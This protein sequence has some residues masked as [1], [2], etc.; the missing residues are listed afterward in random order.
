MGAKAVDRLSRE[1]DQAAGAKAGGSAL[2]ERGI[3]G[4]G[5]DDEGGSGDR[6]PTMMTRQVFIAVPRT[7]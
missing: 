1:G 2:D 6:Y 5:I 3:R 4:L 7:G